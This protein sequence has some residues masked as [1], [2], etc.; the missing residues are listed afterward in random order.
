MTAVTGKYTGKIKEVLHDPSNMGRWYGVSLYSN[1]DHVIHIITVYQSVRSEGIHTAFQQQRHILLNNGITQP[2][3]RKQLLQDLSSQINKWNKNNATIIICIDANEQL[4]SK[5]NLLPK[6]LSETGLVPLIQNPLQY[7][8]THI[9]GSKCIDFIVGS[10]HLLNHISSSGIAP[11]LTN[12]LIGRI[13]EAYSL[14]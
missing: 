4:K 5:E 1:F 7:P 11:F 6:F 8:P 10:Q 13:I 9:R 12:H 3:P 2:N 14:T